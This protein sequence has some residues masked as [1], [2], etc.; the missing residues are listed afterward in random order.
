M[1][2]KQ[3]DTIYLI[4]GIVL[5]VALFYISQIPQETIGLT[6]HYY[7]DGIEVFPQSL[8]SIVNGEVSLGNATTLLAKPAFKSTATFGA[9]YKP[10]VPESTITTSEFSF[11]AACFKRSATTFALNV[12]SALFEIVNTFSAPY[13]YN[14]VASLGFMANTTKLVPNCSAIFFP[15]EVTSNADFL[16]FPSDVSAKT[17]TDIFYFNVRY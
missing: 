10:F 5:V 13:V 16:N 17:K 1:A 12:F 6:P 14:N 8:F 2:K 15:Y 3:D 11:S 7:K 9:R 4:I